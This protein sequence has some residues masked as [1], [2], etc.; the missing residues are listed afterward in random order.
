MVILHLVYQ[1][2][3]KVWLTTVVY[4][5]I[6]TREYFPTFIS[7]ETTRSESVD[8][9]AVLAAACIRNLRQTFKYGGR[10]TLPSKVEVLAASVSQHVLYTVHFNGP[11]ETITV[12]CVSVCPTDNNF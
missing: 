4:E 7:A 9:V 8:R 1:M 3:D 10:Q 11:R 12:F 5:I 6:V 2:S